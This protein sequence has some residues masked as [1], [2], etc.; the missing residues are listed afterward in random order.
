MN[1]VDK[2]KDPVLYR[3]IEDRNLLAQY[4]VLKSAVEVALAHDDFLITHEI[5]L[6]LHQYAVLYICDTPGEYRKRGVQIN[7]SKHAPPPPEKVNGLMD[8]YVTYLNDNWASKSAV[9][10]AAY[11]IWRMCWVHPFME[12]NGRTSRAICCYVMCM[13]LGFWIPGVKTIPKQIRDDRDPYYA[14]LSEADQSDARANYFVLDRME[15]Y[16]TSLLQTQLSS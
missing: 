8:E 2:D 7:G 14:A 10:L 5:I 12:G 9:H 4:D 1:V 13:K 3:Q 11:A 16:L 15:G 6:R